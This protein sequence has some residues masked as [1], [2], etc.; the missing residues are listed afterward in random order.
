MICLKIFGTCE[1]DV[2]T[3]DIAYLTLGISTDR[4]AISIYTETWPERFC[5]ACSN[6]LPCPFYTEPS[7]F[8]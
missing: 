6:N 1:F 3:C 8:L 2:S 5:V 4:F 7:P